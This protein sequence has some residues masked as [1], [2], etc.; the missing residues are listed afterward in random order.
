M[1]P[2]VVPQNKINDINAIKIDDDTLREFYDNHTNFS[3][4]YGKCDAQM[5]AY[6][7]NAM[8]EKFVNYKTS[9]DDEYIRINIE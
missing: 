3:L 6:V 9:I 1:C 4:A 7:D 5:L 2:G 8:R